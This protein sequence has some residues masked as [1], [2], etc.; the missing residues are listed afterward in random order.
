MRWFVHRLLAH[1]VSPRHNF[2]LFAHRIAIRL[3][4][5]Q[6]AKQRL[7][8]HAKQVLKLVQLA[9]GDAPARGTYVAARLL[10][11]GQQFAPA[12]RRG[13]HYPS[14]VVGSPALNKPLLQQAI[15]N[16]GER[17][18]LVV[19][20]ARSDILQHAAAMLQMQEGVYCGTVRSK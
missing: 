19:A 7:H 4:A 20:R 17:C 9:C 5:A 11:G 13:H 2:V 16:A 8:H 18:R 12:R 6:P 1:R 10:D 15:D 3:A 14:P